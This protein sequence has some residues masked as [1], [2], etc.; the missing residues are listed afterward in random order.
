MMKSANRFAY[1]I[2]SILC[3]AAVALQGCQS[4]RPIERVP[5]P[6]PLGA[7]S[8]PIW[9]NQEAN[10]EASDFVV[11]QH[12]FKRDAEWLN[13]A[14][15]DHVKRIAVRLAEGQD[16]TVVVE[17]SMM[18]PRPNTEYGYPVHPHPEL[19]M[20]RR[21]IIVRSLAVMGVADADERVMVAPAMTPGYTSGEAQSSYA[22]GMAA[23][24]GGASGMGGFGGFGGFLFTGGY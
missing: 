22:R 7:L 6:A 24:G 12:E 16:A 4:P 2:A 19:D 23:D 18:S 10:A 15:E 8:D 11:H 9:Q 20:R 14:G 1:A 21:E 3:V 13:T 17:R 5:P